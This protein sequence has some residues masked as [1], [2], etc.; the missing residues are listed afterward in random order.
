[1]PETQKEA[2]RESR[3]LAPVAS[4]HVGLAAYLER[5]HIQADNERSDGALVVV[6]DR[7]YRAYFHPA[8]HG[9]IVIEARLMVLPA[10][11]A[12]AAQTLEEAMR[13]ALDDWRESAETLALAADERT[14][15]QQRRVF[16]Y[17]TVMEFEQALE[18][19]LNALVGWR[20][21]LHVL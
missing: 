18:D 1:M 19:F 7:Q 14:L 6:Y 17:A 9:D 12:N 4:D 8:Q 11:A 10:A 13:L 3:Q 21:S 20:H 2:R 5:N 16:E 15:L